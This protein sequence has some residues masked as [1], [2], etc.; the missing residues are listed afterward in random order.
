MVDV[1]LVDENDNEI[2]KEE[3]LK[4]HL[5]AKTHR[6][7]SIFIFNSK[8]DLMLQK[9][10][11]SKY[12]SGSLW[13]NTCCSH[14]KPDKDIK[15]EVRERLKE[16]MGIDCELK[17]I[18]STLYNVKVH[19]KIGDLMEHEFDHIFIGF[20]EKEPKLNPEEAEDWKWIEINELKQD[21]KNNPEKYTPW[22]HLIL[23]KTLKAKKEL[24]EE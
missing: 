2:G 3:K 8:G 17:E 22:F 13:S 5:D 11:K 21:M 7:F 19:S 9:R 4:A 6:A 1:I 18:L 24:Y 10:A 20:S 12:H 15:E 16:E 14:P 23:D